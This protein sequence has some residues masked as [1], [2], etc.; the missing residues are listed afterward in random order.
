MGVTN[1]KEPLFAY[2]LHSLNLKKFIKETKHFT[3]EMYK[4]T[5]GVIAGS[6]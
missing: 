5:I 3:S 1:K 2:G 4:N 6:K